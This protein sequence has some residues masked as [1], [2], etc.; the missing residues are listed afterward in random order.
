MCADFP[1]LIFLAGIGQLSVLVASALVPFRLD[2][3]SSLKGLPRLHRQLF[4]VYG[5]YTVFSIVS[6]GL[7]CLVCADELASGSRLARVVCAYGSL[8]WGIR[9]SLQ[10]FLDAGPFKTTW[11]LKVG[12][13]VLTVLFASFTV[14]LG[15]AALR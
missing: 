14:I 5:G 6:L 3:Q 4:W 9:L 11:W 2:W 15:A 8:F 12:Y 1:R 7:I 10:P 13:H